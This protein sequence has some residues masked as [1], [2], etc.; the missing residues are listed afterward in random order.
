M[1]IFQ[2]D[3][4]WVEVTNLDDLSSRVPH[5][6]VILQ[7]DVLNNSR[8]ATVVVCPLT[9]NIKRVSLPG[10][11]LLEVGEANLTRQSVVEVAKISTLQKTLLGDYIGTLSQQRISQIFAG[12]RFI[13][14]SFLCSAAIP[15][16]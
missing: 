13:Q 9:S 3:I 10:N 8:I 4:Y 2:G 6:Y 5:P 7:D 12:I 1:S 14:R 11:V 15:G 16:R